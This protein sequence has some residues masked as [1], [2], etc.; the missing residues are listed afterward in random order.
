MSDKSKIEWTDATAMIDRGGCR[1]RYYKRKNPSSSSPGSQLRR[2]MA[3]QGK[4]WCR[5]CKAWLPV[6]DM[7]KNGLCREHNRQD[8]R[9]RYA[10]NPT[11]IRARVHARKRGVA[12]V[13]PEASL[14]AELFDNK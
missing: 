10:V 13:P 3:A 6:A 11:T 8:Y 5:A 9:E 14:I 2:A 7:T 1:V 4:R 12:P